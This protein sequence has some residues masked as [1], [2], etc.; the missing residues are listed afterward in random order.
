MTLRFNLLR[1][2]ISG[3]LAAAGIGFGGC[4]STYDVTVH[5]DA[6]AQAATRTGASFR[7]VDRSAK[8][9]ASELRR[10]EVAEHLKTALS[11]QGLYEAADAPKADIVV[12][13]SYELGPPHVE[14]TVYQEI[15]HGRSVPVGRRI[16]PAPEGVAAAAM[17]YAAVASTTVTREKR[18]TICARENRAHEDG[19]PG[20]DLWRV[21]VS[22]E[23]ESEDLRG[24]LPV[25]ASVAMD[26]IGRPTDGREA[27]TMRSD[28]EAIQFV[29]KGM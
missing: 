6:R 25:L 7:I 27:V 15:I 14:R 9:D 4:A 13:L 23:D 19:S 11:A 16:G 3:L 2:G 8:P 24:H 20:D 1:W 28:D 18:L 21:D 22:I 12:E 5:S 17:G 26:H 10:N 29:K